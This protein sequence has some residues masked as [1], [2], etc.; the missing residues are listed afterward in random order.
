MAQYA[1]AIA[2]GDFPVRWTNDYANYGMPL[3]LYAH[4]LPAYLGAFLILI[5]FSTQSA[6]IVL[7]TLCVIGVSVATY[8]FLRTFSSIHL[9]FTATVI[10]SFFPYKILNIY[11]RGALPE[12]LAS[13]FLPILCFSF[14]LIS[15][16]KYVYG[17]V[18]L[19]SS[20]FLLA[21]THPMMLLVFFI[22][23]VAY[24]LLTLEHK[25]KILLKNQ[26]SVVTISGIL[27]MCAASFYLMP[28]VLEMKY[29]YQANIHDGISYDKFLAVKQLFD[30]SWYYTYTHSGPRGNYITL[31][32]IEFAILVFA[33][34]LSLSQ[35]IKAVRR[36]KIGEQLSKHKQLLVWT[37]VA[38]VSILL[39]LPISKIV[40]DTLPMLSQLQYPWRFLSSLQFVIPILFVLVAQQISIFSKPLFL[41]A[42]TVLVLWLRIPELYGK[43]YVDQSNTDFAFTRSNLHSVNLNPVW[44]GNSE[45]YPVREAQMAVLD[46][47]ADITYSNVKNSHR[48]Y[49]V[50]SVT[51][52][53][54]I[55]YTFYFP[56]WEVTN[57]GEKLVI[58]YQDHVYRGLITYTIPAG[59]N[60]IVVAYKNTKVRLFANLVSAIS[61]VVAGIYFY[62]Q[63]QRSRST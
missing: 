63:K 22:P 23:A 18:M 55:D 6:F 27:G 45:S 56:G 43:N 39:L 48:E 4:Q 16:K 19:F 1:S 2:D 40:Y 3:P 32:T 58:E 46:G 57:N 44:T 51:P 52:T 29:F 17:S 34:F 21:I 42:I 50:K 13:I 31:G 12:L 62:T 53:R 54:M 11:T 61:F 60:N 59:E 49:T 24:F 8:A 37:A 28:L 14:Y 33:V 10:G 26:L 9:A 30:P 47:Q 5:G 20:L 41:I 36:K 7:L 25:N 35:L 38:C 15:K